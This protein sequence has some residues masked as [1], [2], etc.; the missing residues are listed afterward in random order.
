M[1]G[2]RVASGLA[3]G[4]ATAATAGAAERT[5]WEDIPPNE[6]A[7]VCSATLKETRQ[8]LHGQTQAIF[9]VPM[10]AEPVRVPAALLTPPPFGARG[11]E[12]QHAVYEHWTEARDAYVKARNDRFRELLIKS[13]PEEAPNPSASCQIETFAVASS[14]GRSSYSVIFPTVIGSEIRDP[15]KPDDM[16]K[17]VFAKVYHEDFLPP[18]WTKGLPPF[19]LAKAEPGPKAPPPTPA[20]KLAPSTGGSLTVKQDTSA[21]DVRRAWDAQVAK[22]LADEAQK[23]AQTAIK[24]AQN[25]A[26]MQAD[27][28][29]ARQERV[30][31]GRAQ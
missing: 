9:H 29:R 15:Y 28:E 1:I 19:A 3:A 30:K 20:P 13:R 12:A 22:A 7:L 11:D 25:D 10:S 27:A 5:G 23:R 8:V 24:Q 26:K 14:Y 17:P 6:A 2:R 21:A 18:D 16:S 4:L 31:R